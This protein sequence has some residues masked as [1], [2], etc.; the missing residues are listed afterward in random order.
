MAKEQ[1][2]R[3]PWWRSIWFKLAVLATA[4]ALGGALYWQFRDQLQLAYVAQR[5]ADLRAALQA[6][7]VASYAAAF[8]IYVVVTGLSLPGAAALSLV[9]GWLFGFWP[10]LVLVS[11]ASTSGATIA[12]LLSRFLIGETI[13]RRYGD[14]LGTFNQSLKREGP[15]FLFTL[16]LMPVVPFFVIN[17]LMG[18]TPIRVRTFWWVSQL[19]MLPGTC[20]YIFAGS[21]V[22]TAKELAR[23]GAASLL[24]PQ[25]II[26]FVIL[27]VFPL[28]VRYGLKL[29]GRSP[30]KRV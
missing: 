18:L 5:E 10:A 22:P 23:Q 1:F 20:V 4:A 16:R 3:T 14:R 26:A 29:F 27:G 2:T 9:Y 6:H 24:S 15:F 11:F 13:Q 7:P 17:L 30:Q 21:T 8:V 19:G 28:V 25:L 12:F